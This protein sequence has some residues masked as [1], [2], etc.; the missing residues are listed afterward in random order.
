MHL[1]PPP[2]PAPSSSSGHRRT[3]AVLLLVITIAVGAWWLLDRLGPRTAW[4][5]VE[6]PAYAIAG[7]GLRLRLS[8]APLPE[9]ALVCAD[10][11]WGITRDQSEGYLASGGIRSVGA[12]GGTFDFWVPLPRTNLLHYVRVVVYLSQDGSWER[13]ARVAATEL[14]PVRSDPG[15]RPEQRLQALRL[16]A[17]DKS[18]NG[19]PPPR[20]GLRLAAGLLFLCAA[21]LAWS[22]RGGLQVL[23]EP[24][25]RR[26]ITLALALACLWELLALEYWI[27]TQA[28]AIALAGDMYY[29]R[30]LFQKGVISAICGIAAVGFGFLARAPRA[31]RLWLGAFGLYAALSAVNLI[32]LHTIDRIAELSWHGVTLIYALKLCCAA[33]T[34]LGVWTACADESDRSRGECGPNQVGTC[35]P[36]HPGPV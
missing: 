16:E 24:R 14:I 4:L 12:A 3:G 30:A 5:Q 11:H 27:G 19:H 1:Q 20:S 35:D 33:L 8:V 7:Q 21:V 36:A 17:M 9:P 23:A 34:L 6:G 18:A 15:V 10:V 28:R 13:R 22:A 26:A 31:H 25:W 29:P 32:S 2:G